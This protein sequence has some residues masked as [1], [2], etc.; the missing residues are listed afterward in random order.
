MVIERGQIYWV[1]L[2]TPRQSEPGY[3][4]P[5]LV[6]QSDPLNQSKL[7]TVMLCAISS[8]TALARIGGNLLLLPKESGL[9]RK[10]VVLMHQ[11]VTLNRSDLGELIG[12]IPDHLM[13]SVDEGLRHSLSL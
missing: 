5:M 9:P 12:K 7:P 4:R 11:I 8:N 10:S 1:D 6:I 2:S 13:L 3:R